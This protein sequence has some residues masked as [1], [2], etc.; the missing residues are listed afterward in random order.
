MGLFWFAWTNSP[1]IHW[2]VSIAAEVSF[3]FGIVL[4]FLGI[5]NYLINAYT[6]FAASVL[7]AGAILYA[8]FIFAFPLFT[9]Y[10]YH[11]LG[12]HWASSV[13]AFLSIL[14]LPFPFLLYKYG[15]AIQ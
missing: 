14:C 13:P 3:G 9:T 4:I 5:T 7:T 2:M 15:L 10:M 6:I 1:S 8:L 11:N 12:I